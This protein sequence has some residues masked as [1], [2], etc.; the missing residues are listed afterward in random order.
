M[1]RPRHPIKELECLLREAERQGWI[2]EKGRKYFKIYCPCG[3]HKHTVHLTPSSSGYERN[4]RGHL[5]RQTC[6]E[7]DVP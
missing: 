3:A 2:V 5:R 4:L 1:P 6:R 7:E